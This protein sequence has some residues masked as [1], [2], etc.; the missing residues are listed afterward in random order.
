MAQNSHVVLCT[1]TNFVYGVTLR[2]ACGLE[3]CVFASER[4]V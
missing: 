1:G 2:V 3:L 4:L